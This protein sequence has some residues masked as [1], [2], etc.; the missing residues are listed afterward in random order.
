MVAKRAR[1]NVRKL[2]L[3]NITRL[4]VVNVL[5]NIKLRIRCSFEKSTGV[6]PA[7]R[8]PKLKLALFPVSVSLRVY[9]PYNC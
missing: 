1:E 6:L 2:F 7:Y 3:H 9:E 8:R 4:G 5:E